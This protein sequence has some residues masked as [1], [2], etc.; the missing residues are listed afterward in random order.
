MDNLNAGNGPHQLTQTARFQPRIFVYFSYPRTPIPMDPHPNRDIW[1]QTQLRRARQRHATD[2]LYR[3]LQEPAVQ[4]SPAVH[5]AVAHCLNMA[6]FVNTWL[7]AAQSTKESQK[8][9]V[10]CS[11]GKRNEKCWHKWLKYQQNTS[12][13]RRHATTSDKRRKT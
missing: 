9:A 12:T 11:L 13:A 2:S 5:T 6:L 8:G 1:S 10:Y 7:A 3:M 4:H